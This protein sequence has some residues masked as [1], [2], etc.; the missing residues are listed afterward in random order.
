MGNCY[1][2]VLDFYL[3]RIEFTMKGN[4]TQR[5]DMLDMILRAAGWDDMLNPE[6]YRVI[7]DNVKKAYI[8]T[9]EDNYNGN[10]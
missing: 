7:L 6:E 9:M 8:K 5:L 3:G 1:P 10:W 2:G 4:F